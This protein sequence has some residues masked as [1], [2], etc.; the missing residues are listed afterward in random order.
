MNNNE[1][2]WRDLALQFDGHRMQAIGFLKIILAELPDDQFQSARDFLN[3]GPLSGEEVLQERL[4]AM[5]KDGW[6]NWDG[7][8]DPTCE[9]VRGRVKVRFRDGEEDTGNASSYYWAH[10]TDDAYHADIVAY[11]IVKGESDE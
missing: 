7:N 5:S 6:I 2:K 1:M 8:I 3:A 9:P 11:S 4:L 10:D